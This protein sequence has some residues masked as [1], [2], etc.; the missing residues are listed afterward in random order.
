VSRPLGGPGFD[1]VEKAVA[2]IRRYDMLAGGEKVLVALS[3]GPD[4]TCL[5]DVLRRLSDRFDLTLEVGHIDHGLSEGSDAVAGRVAGEAAEAGFEVHLVRA[6]DLSGPNLHARAREFRYA[7]LETVARGVGADRIATGH[8]LDDR[9]ETLLAR[10]LHGAPPEVLAGIP[11][12]DDLR[13]RPLLD[14]RRWESRR[15]CEQTGLAFTDDPG[16]LD[17]RFERVRVRERL[18]SAIDETWGDGAVRAIARAAEHLR[19]DTSAL[20]A[21]ADRLYGEL[22]EATPD[23]IRLDRPGLEAMPR[24]LRRRLLEKAVGRVRDRSGG[25]EAALNAL[26]SGPSSRGTKFSV[27]SGLE[28]EVRDSDVL[29]RG[30][31]E[32]AEGQPLGSADEF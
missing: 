12:R 31:A 20:N 23:G 2:T 5:F 15:Y 24:A 16:N 28:I 3:G 27:A 29:V 7:F 13:I 4:S 10:L 26:D 21:L 30:E 11:P 1:L 18:V 19:V 25:I 32:V 9:V 8:T 17:D 6:P 14:V 22:A